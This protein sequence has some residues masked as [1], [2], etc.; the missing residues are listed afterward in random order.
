VFR[1]IGIVIGICI[2]ALVALAAFGLIL[3]RPLSDERLREIGVIESDSLF[4]DVDGVRTR[5]ITQGE[6]HE[7]IVFIHGFSSSLYTWRACLEAIAKHYR[8]YALDLK[9]FGFSEKPPSEYTTDEYAEFVV[10]FMDAVGLKTATLCGNS[11]GGQI[12]WRIALQYPDRVDKLILVDAGGYPSSRRGLPFFVK[13]AKLP[14]IGEALG[15]FTSRDRIRSSV[16]SA[17]YDDSKVTQ[18]TVDAYYYSL[19]TEGAMHAVLARLRGSW[20]EQKAWVPRIPELKVPTLIIWGENDTW[21]PLEDGERFHKDIP[22][23]KLVVLRDCGHVPQE[24]KPG[25]FLAHVLEFL[26]EHEGSTPE[27]RILIDGTI[28]DHTEPPVSVLSV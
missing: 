6:G 22:G 10:H 28:P 20:S 17:Y 12:A 25:E 7:T 11:M 18:Q 9:G 13:L 4:V 21:I 23:S 19:K 8:V 15:A 2:A 24:E 5:Y 1:K 14:G 27:E 26:S 3:S 16:E